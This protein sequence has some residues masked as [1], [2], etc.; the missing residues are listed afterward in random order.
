MVKIVLTE[1]VHKLV[2][3]NTHVFTPTPKGERLTS[4]NTTYL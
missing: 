4:T 3:D 2:H 1:R